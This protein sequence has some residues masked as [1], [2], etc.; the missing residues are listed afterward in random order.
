LAFEA[1]LHRQQNVPAPY[2]S[3]R[4]GMFSEMDVCHR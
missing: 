4:I 1:T 2:D 3:R